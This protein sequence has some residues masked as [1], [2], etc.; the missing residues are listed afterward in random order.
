[1]TPA[2]LVLSAGGLATAAS[3]ASALADAET[4]GLK[5]RVGGDVDR[6][7]DDMTATV[8]ELFQAGRPIIGLCAAGILIRMIA[9]LLGAKRQ[10]PPVLAVSEDG[11]VVVPLIGGLTG[12]N[13]LAGAIASALGTTAAITGSGARAFGVILERPPQGWTCANPDDAKRVTADLLAG[14][15]ARVEGELPWLA[16]T[17]I[18]VADRGDVLLRASVHVEAPPVRGLLYRPRCVVAAVT[19]GRTDLAGVMSEAGIDAAAL[20]AVVLPADGSTPPPRRMEAP[21]RVLDGVFAS[22]GALALAAAGEGARLMH[23]ADGAALAAARSPVDPNGIGRPRGRVA[24]VGLGPGTEAWRTPEA[25]AEIEAASDIVGYAPYIAQLPERVRAR[26]RCHSSDNRVEIERARLALDLAAAGMRVAV[27]SSGDPGIFAMAAAL[28]EALEE[29]RPGWASVEIAVLPGISA[30]QAAA[31]R[32][33]A[34]LGHDFAAI[35]LSDNLKPWSVIERRLKAALSADLVLALYNPVSR[36]RPG[37]LAET[38]AEV[39]RHRPADTPIVLGSDVGRSGE[40]VRVV[41]LA[42]FTADMADSR[43]VV[44]VGSSRTRRF[45]FGSQAFVYTPRHYADG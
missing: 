27:V 24:V 33:G 42:D 20:A 15:Q 32:V 26:A 22:A 17:A 5:G 6:G 36:A 35:S 23:E 14:A 41:A 37:R 11:R 34:P 45:V 10:E 21:V 8:R 7:F 31:A 30:M 9:P 19:A 39:A 40:R 18:P 2:I 3:I 38:M 43:T 28:M 44:L 12:G 29:T 13:E 25:T 4:L 16:D 1:M